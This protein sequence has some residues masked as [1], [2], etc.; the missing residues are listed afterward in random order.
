MRID[1]GRTIIMRTL[2]LTLVAAIATTSMA[3][4]T[5]KDIDAPPMAGPSSLARTIIMTADRDTLLQDGLQEAAIRLTAQV[6]P[7]QSEN[8]RL[9][10]QV[11]VDGVA[12][13]FGTLSN[14]NP[15]TPTT[16]FYRAPAAPTTLAGQVSTRVTIV[17]TP[18]DSG[19]FRGEL[20][21]ELDLLLIPPGVIL[22]SNPSLA[23]DF[24][25]APTAP[26]VFDTVTFDASTTT[27][28]GVACG[29]N[30]SYRWNFGDNTGG[31]GM[32]VNHTFRTVD[33]FQV[34]LTVTDA[35]GAQAVAIKPVTVGAGEPPTA[36][37]T[38][39]PTQPSPGRTI[40]FNASTSK[41]AAGRFLTEYSWDF[42]DGS[43]ATGV[44]ASHTYDEEGTYVVI[45]TVKDNAGSSQTKTQ[46]IDVKIP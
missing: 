2:K 10:A 24:K 5:I 44:S 18:D 25:F 27:N 42:G 6:Q 43:T 20:S 36:D 21:R 12:Q 34:T 35:R 16:I 7:G 19:D 45:L 9:R 13:D 33:T 28:G 40:F 14:K 17:V 46:D 31:D 3:A 38:F 29:Q 22:P 26:R 30:C 4:C 1:T 41:A 32:I 11:Y 39:S 8:V 15:I 37:F 23:A